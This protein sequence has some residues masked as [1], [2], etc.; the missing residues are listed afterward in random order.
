MNKEVMAIETRITTGGGVPVNFTP[1]CF[2]DK[3]LKSTLE[4]NLNEEI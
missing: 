4:K 1:D 2:T 3:L